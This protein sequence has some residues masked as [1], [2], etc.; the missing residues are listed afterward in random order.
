LTIHNIAFAGVF[1]HL[2]MPLL[3]LDWKLFN[4][5]QLEFYGKVSFLKAG[6]VFSDL[7]NTVSPTYAREI[8]TPYFGCGLHGV[9]TE[10]RSR[11]SGIVNGVDYSVWDPAHDSHLPAHYTP[12][13]LEP[14]K[15]ACKAALQQRLGL[16][17]DPSAPLLGWWRA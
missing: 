5:R 10:V 1:W 8:Q 15:P 17:S 4:H 14:G 13:A 16:E 12:E 3:G 2:D 6:I 7:I 9:L 11:L